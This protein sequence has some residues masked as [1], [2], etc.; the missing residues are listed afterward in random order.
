V[1]AAGCGAALADDGPDLLPLVGGAKVVV[2]ALP[3]SRLAALDMAKVAAE[4]AEADRKGAP[5]GF[6]YAVPAKV[7]VD[8]ATQGGW[9]QAKDGRAVWHWRVRSPD[10][11]H[12]NF[13]FDR[14]FLP[15]G[16][17]LRI[18]AVEGKAMLG[19]YTSADNSRHRQLWTAPLFARDAVIEV[20]VPDGLKSG[21]ELHLAQVGVGYRG[22]GLKSKHCKSGACNTDV[23]CLG[24]DDPFN[25][26]RRAV[27]SYSLGGGR[28]C[29]GSLL[30]N[31][32]GDRR[33]LFVTA[34]HCE[35]TSTNAASLVVFWN[36]ESPT[37]RTP[38]SPQSG[39]SAI[40]GPT[41]QTQN[42]ATFLAA[43]NSPFSGSGSADS[44][45]D[46]TLL[47]LT[48]PANPA[49]N[50]YW[51][52][53]DRRASAPYCGPGAPCA[54]IH[55]PDGD[56]KR[57]TFSEIPMVQGDIA[58]AAG[59]HWTVQW[60]STPP[61]ERLPN[62]PAPLPTA[63]PP[64]AT[65]PG[66][67]GSPMYNAQQRLVGVLSGG[68]SFC[69]A[70]EARL[71]DEYG[72]LAKAWDGLGTTATR[73]RDA[74]DPVGGGSAETLDG[75]GTCTAPT[76]DFTAPASIAA[77]AAATFAVNATGAGPF[78]VEFDYD[79]DGVFDATATGVA[80]SV[81]RQATFPKRGGVSVGARVT[82]RNNCSAFV[83]RA[84]VVQ[85]PDVS[86]TAQAPQ[87]VC[88][89]GDGDVD[90]GERWRI[91]VSLTNGGEIATQEAAA[92]FT[93]GQGTAGGGSTDAFG[94]RL[95]DSTGASCPYSYVDISAEASLA[96]TGGNDDARVTS[97]LDLGP[98]GVPFYGA[99]V[100][101]VVMS[102]NGYLAIDPS[103]DG[104]DFEN[105]CGL[106]A[107]DGGRLNVLHDD[108]VVKT[109]GALR[110]RYFAT[111]PR[112]SDAG[113]M[114]G[115]TVFQWTGLGRFVSGAEPD[116]NADFQAV[117]YDNGQ[118]VYQYRAPDPLGAGSATIS[119]QD[120]A[121]NLQYAC[122]Q[123]SRID[124]GRAVCFFPPAALPPSLQAP[125]VVLSAARDLGNLAPAASAAREVEFAVDPNAGCGAPLAV[126][127]VGTVDRV[128]HSLRPATILDT[129]VGG[130][131][132]TCSAQPQCY[133]DAAALPLPARRDGSF[134]NFSRLG[135]GMAAFNYTNGNQWTFGGGWFTATRDH[136]P[137]WYTVQGDFGDRRLNAQ[138]E[139][140]IFRF[141]QTSSS[142]FAVQSSVAGTGQI[143]YITPTDLVF[144]W[145]LDGVPA[146]ER[147]VLAYTGQRATPE[148]TGAWFNPGESGWGVL[149]EDAAPLPGLPIDQLVVNYLYDAA[150]R[151]TW[152]LGAV[153]GTTG[154]TAQHRVFFVH[155]PGCPAIV[156]APTAPAGSSTIGFSGLTTGTYS[157]N[158][159]LPSPLSGTWVRNNLPLQMLSPPQPAQQ[160]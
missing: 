65:E 29:T 103:D 33:M 110:R 134:A 26:P 63:L 133:P 112:A 95:L 57:I 81:Q 16:A 136:L 31:T 123:A 56:E 105:A 17:T 129:R 79:D 148:R 24:A 9:Q 120:G 146:G 109:G 69:G 39:S 37:C 50:L 71:N 131:D 117:V 114:V 58:A 14:F 82:D 139:V 48:Q 74:L 23:A 47:E 54:S 59:V 107:S 10:A 128:S 86:I 84:V 21:L 22:F 141:R 153:P 19:P 13:G 78:R 150:G 32:R 102:T 36:F 89:N 88:G 106:A 75:I 66:S 70:D 83:R 3:A 68:A 49:F 145:T 152:T 151:P 140:Q 94:N 72:Q 93:R 98:N 104:Q 91:P 6:R 40:V 76:V 108:F 45:S 53:W 154:G 12:L 90:P 41:N 4:D 67:S 64:S 15:E 5:G 28:I 52:G 137:T 130:T 156:D 1:V 27:A 147:M 30:N 125:R 25:L 77:G 97:A 127:Y 126:R 135:N 11:L 142:P 144:T 160:P 73:V 132:G 101:Q 155:C 55:H 51:A 138:A 99:T 92:I 61:I 124:A 121:N 44:R 34:T 60:D 118:I 20:A 100:R 159:T 143:T 96:L 43:T 85:A 62:L 87:Q 157:T 35:V 116:G 7:A 42:G 113:G 115:C 122:N 2:D 119:I 38:G 46:F 111:C 8:A 158:I 149:L 80:A 18:L